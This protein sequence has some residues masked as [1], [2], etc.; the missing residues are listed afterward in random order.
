[1]EKPYVL[2]TGKLAADL[3]EVFKTHGWSAADAYELAQKA[4]KMALSK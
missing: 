3:R 1:M 4:L 2:D